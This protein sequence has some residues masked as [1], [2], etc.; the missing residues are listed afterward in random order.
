MTT[1][2]YES[3]KARPVHGL[4]ANLVHRGETLAASK[5]LMGNMRIGACKKSNASARYRPGFGPWFLA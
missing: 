1:P 2:A 5:S 4:G 3:A